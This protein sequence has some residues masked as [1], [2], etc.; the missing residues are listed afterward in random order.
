MIKELKLVWENGWLRRDTNHPD[1]VRNFMCGQMLRR[2]VVLPPSR[3][4]PYVYLM[5]SDKRPRHTEYFR[6]KKDFGWRLD[7]VTSYPHPHMSCVDDFL[8]KCMRGYGKTCYVWFE[9]EE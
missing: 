8:S 3:L 4:C 9:T 6:L 7:E 5:V 2:R 1:F